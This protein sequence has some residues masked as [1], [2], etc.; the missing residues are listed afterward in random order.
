[1]KKIELGNGHNTLIDDD[2]FYIINQYKWLLHKTRNTSYAKNLLI[3]G[4]IQFMHRQIMNPPINMSIDHIDGNGLNNQKSN[5]RLCTH[6]QNMCNRKSWGSSIYLG[7]SKRNVKYKSKNG[8]IIYTYF[9]AE[10]C[11]NNKDL[12]L[13]SFKSEIEAALTYNKAAMKYHGEFAR[14]NKI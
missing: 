4:K 13:G 3:D 8:I 5:L 11:V 6:S 1:M 12:F 2:D 9:F 10:I 14:L 7:V